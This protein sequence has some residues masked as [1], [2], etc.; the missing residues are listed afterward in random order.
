MGLMRFVVPRRERLAADVLQRAYL[1]G[2]DEIPWVTR[3][4]WSGD[5]LAVRRTESDSGTFHIP[6]PGAGLGELTLGTA[7]LLEREA[8]YHLPVELARGTLNRLRHQIAQWQSMGMVVPPEVTTQ[9]A[10]ALKV[11]ARAATSQ[12]DSAAAEALAEQALMTGLA[13]VRRLTAAYAEQILAVRRRNS[14]KR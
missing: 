14:A 2:L 7:C 6:W 13:A 4:Q 3:V 9:L 1:S 5:E 10:A 12:H 11:F 8:P